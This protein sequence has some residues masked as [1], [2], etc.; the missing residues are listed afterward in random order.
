MKLFLIVGL[1]LSHACLAR[2]VAAVAAARSVAKSPVSLQVG[3]YNIGRDGWSKSFTS[4]AKPPLTFRRT[5]WGPTRSFWTKAFAALPPQFRKI[6]F[7]SRATF[8]HCPAQALASSS[9]V[10]TFRETWVAFLCLSFRSC[11]LVCFAFL[12]RR[13]CDSGYDSHRFATEWR[14]SIADGGTWQ[15]VVIGG[16]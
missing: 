12:C 11:A 16:P 2:G 7:T 8:R 14:V 5:S 10:F 3:F 4:V 9:S 15:E 13:G 1:C 6:H